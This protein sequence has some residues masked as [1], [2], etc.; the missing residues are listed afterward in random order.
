[1]KSTRQSNTDKQIF[2]IEEAEVSSTCDIL[3]SL[4]QKPEIKRIAAGGFLSGIGGG[5]ASTIAA[6]VATTNTAVRTAACLVGGVTC[7]L[8]ACMVCSMAPCICKRCENENEEEQTHVNTESTDLIPKY[9]GM[10]K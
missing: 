10:C 2:D 9:R 6:A 4:A 3:K 1:M 5:I 8:F 7:G